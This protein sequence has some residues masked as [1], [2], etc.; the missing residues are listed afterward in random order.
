MEQL[1]P[2]RRPLEA[3]D[4]YRNLGLAELAP[5]DRPYVIANM[6]ASVDGRATL[7]GRSGGLGNDTDHELFLDL[8][9]QTDAVMAGTATLAIERY[10]PLIRSAARREQRRALGLEETPAAVTATRSMELPVQV[11]LFQDPDS[12]IIVLTSSERPPPPCPATL[13]AERVG[14][15]AIDLVAGMKRL[16]E[17]HGIRSLLLE[18]GPTLLA[19]M[20]AAGVVD[21]L[22]LTGSPTLVGSSD[23]PAILE[24]PAL[25]EP[26]ELELVSLLRDG[27]YLF[28]RYRRR[29]NSNPK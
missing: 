14:D 8:R 17:A 27:S 2:E 20:T 23:Q 26:I 12:R 4:A 28:A 1:Y 24:G 21:E 15:G 13:F 16:R 22:F 10:G 3:G 11:P 7:G 19:A 25:E 18:G 6:V 9:T 5:P 29:A